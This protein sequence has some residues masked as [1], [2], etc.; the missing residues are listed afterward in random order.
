M[1]QGTVVKRPN[2]FILFSMFSLFSKSNNV[3]GKICMLDDQKN[4]TGQSIKIVSQEFP[5]DFVFAEDCSGYKDT[6]SIVEFI[7]IPYCCFWRRAVII[8]IVGPFK[9]IQK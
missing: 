7:I 2:Q 5:A 4:V 1:T 6:H 8:N 9:S 3:N